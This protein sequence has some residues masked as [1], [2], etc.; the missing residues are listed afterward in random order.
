MFSESRHSACSSPPSP[1]AIGLIFDELGLQWAF[2][3]PRHRPRRVLALI[4]GALWLR[5]APTAAKGCIPTP[6]PPSPSKSKPPRPSPTASSRRRPHLSAQPPREPPSKPPARHP[7]P[8]P[9]L[10]NHLLLAIPRDHLRIEP[11]R[12]ASTSVRLLPRCRR[13][14][15]APGP[16]S[17]SASARSPPASLCRP[18]GVSTSTT[19]LRAML[20]G[21][22]KNSLQRQHRRRADIHR[23]QDREPL[24]LRLRLEA[25]PRSAP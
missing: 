10:R 24:V 11:Q 4:S 23:V 19:I 25:P 21:S 6:T 15:T 14:V 17:R 22:A 9:H 13:R 16:A 7:N 18:S 2:R 1:S 12:S 3:N 20:C 8:Q 5:S